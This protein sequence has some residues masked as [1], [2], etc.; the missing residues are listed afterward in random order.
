MDDA[1]APS[2]LVPWF[3]N[4]RLLRRLDLLVVAQQAWKDIDE[5]EQGTRGWL[6]LCY[7]S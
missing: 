2:V 6:F 1:E 5:A 3:W 7:I 4:C